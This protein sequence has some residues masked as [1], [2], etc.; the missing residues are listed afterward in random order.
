MKNF[1]LAL[2]IVGSVMF[3]S[4]SHAAPPAND[5][6]A[7]AV[8]LSGPFGSAPGTT[9][10][11]TRQGGE[12]AETGYFTTWY[13]WTAPSTG[14]ARFSALPT[15][16]GGIAFPKLSIWFGNDF[17]NLVLLGERFQY[18]Q[19]VLIE[20]LPVLAGAEYSICVGSETNVASS[21]GGFEC[22][23][24]LQTSSDLSGRNVV[25]AS[26]QNTVFS[27]ATALTG[28]SATAISYGMRAALREA[29]EP[30]R[31]P[32]YSSWWKWT[33]PANGYGNVS[34]AG[35]EQGDFYVTYTSSR[36]MYV[37]AVDTF[38]EMT[39]ATP[40]AGSN[41]PYGL[42][43]NLSFPVTANQTYYVVGGGGY[44][45]DDTPWK[46]LTVQYSTT[47]PAI[48]AAKAALNAQI[49]ATKQ[50]LKRAK[51]AKAKKVL[52]KRLASLQRQL[53]AL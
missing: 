34:M 50:A 35:T 1:S 23:V 4:V 7:N 11:A 2:G 31:N 13:K 33:A 38:A 46:V 12:Q 48:Q 18:D 15:A 30:A 44:D 53:R 26:S 14:R 32:D 51:T 9:V 24:V 19:E 40:V 25:A 41:V 6:Y 37:Y 49:A 29:G 43:A 8:Q 5:A 27:Q 42:P 3:I 47:S 39:T 52:R 20:G 22:T 10:D 21:Q 16:S 28:N 17:P 36:Q 45:A